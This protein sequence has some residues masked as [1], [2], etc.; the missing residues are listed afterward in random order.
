VIFRVT[1][2]LA[3]LASIICPAF[4]QEQAPVITL[5]RTACFGTCPVYSLEIFENGFTR[6]VGTDFVQSEGERRA[7]IRHEAVEDLIAL[8]L[9]ADYFA[10]KEDYET[11]RAP[12]GTSQFVTDLPTTYTSLRVGTKKKSVR[13]YACGPERLTRLEEEIDKIANT[14][15]WI[16][17][18]IP[19]DRFFH[20]IEAPKL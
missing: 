9:R 7:V 10:L 20:A 12:D 6:Y 19:F 13:N 3:F 2:L 8:F 11:C 17:D 5:R 16:G 18:P 1:L 14:H 15:R 4:A